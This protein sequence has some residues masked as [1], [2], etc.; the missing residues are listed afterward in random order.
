[1]GSRRCSLLTTLAAKR[2]AAKVIANNPRRPVCRGTALICQISGAEISGDYAAC[3]TALKETSL[4][5]YLLNLRGCKC[6]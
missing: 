4:L 2:V 5:V 1:M 3:W 6:N